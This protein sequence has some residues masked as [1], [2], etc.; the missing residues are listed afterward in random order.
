MLLF[1]IGIIFGAALTICGYV[2]LKNY[3]RIKD[4]IWKK[5]FNE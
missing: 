2:V 5:L 4:W 3:E 1:N